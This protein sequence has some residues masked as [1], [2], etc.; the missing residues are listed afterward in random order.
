MIQKVGSRNGGP[1]TL[2]LS[3]P[4]YDCVWSTADKR[5]IAFG[6]DNNQQDREVEASVSAFWELL[7]YGERKSIRK[8]L[9]AYP[10]QSEIQHQGKSTS[11]VGS[12]QA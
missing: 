8:Q 12:I 10:R 6:G 3:P 5:E 1:V 11:W 2:Q 9:D 4:K 7:V